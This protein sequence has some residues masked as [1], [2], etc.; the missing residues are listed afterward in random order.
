MDE[1]SSEK[2]GFLPHLVELRERVI[3]SLAA[4]LVC[5]IALIPWAPEIYNLF[6]EPFD[7]PTA[8]FKQKQP[9]LVGCDGWWDV[10][11]CME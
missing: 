8:P 7:H 6:A 9:V 2:Q 3:K 1:D 5:F 11:P 4:V 10:V